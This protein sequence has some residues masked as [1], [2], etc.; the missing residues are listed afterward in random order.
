MMNT[1]YF[2][3]AATTPLL[4]E[5]ANLMHE[6]LL[7]NYGNPSSIHATGRKAKGLIEE[8]RVKIAKLM[9]CTPSEIYF[10]SGGTESDNIALR[11]SIDCLGIKNII[12][13]PIEHHAVLTTAENICHQ[14]GIK[15]HLLNVDEKGNYQLSELENLLQQ[16][17]HCLVSLMHANNELGNL[18]DLQQIGQ[19][20][21][22]NKA[23]F[24]TDAVQTVGYFNFNL[25]E[26]PIDFLSASAHKFNGPK[27]IG[28]V[29]VRKGLK[30]DGLITG[31]GQERNMRAGTENV[32]SIVGM[33]KAL[34]ICYNNLAAKT[35]Q[36]S[37]V[38]NYFIEQIVKEIPGINFNGDINNSHYTVVNLALPI[39]SAADL[40]LFNLD[41]K[42]VAAS[43][44]SA[45]SSGAA[46]GSHVLN[47]IKAEEQKTNLRFSFGIFNNKAEVDTVISILK[48]MIAANAPLN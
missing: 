44:G 27:G 42:G 28:F 21:K 18:A 11:K 13:S 45:C 41:M 20:C 29:F 14:S 33:A 25:T 36:I 48:E 8:S 5:V 31:G 9:G 35:E 46:A 43:G 47:A 17:E 6:I 19:I 15:L 26:D 34:E 7:N 30:C 4:P 16:N 38:R 24:H 10:T 40:F 2:D 23:I 12:T 3:N 1:I 22:E 37:S 39:N 32:A